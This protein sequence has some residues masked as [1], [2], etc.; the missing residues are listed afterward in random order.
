[1]T[2]RIEV[3]DRLLAEAMQAG[4]FKT[5]RAAVEVALRLLARKRAYREILALR[6]TV[7]WDGDPGAL[8]RVKKR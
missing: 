7:H 1:M 4:G 2:T 6:H 3:D 8:R 5:K